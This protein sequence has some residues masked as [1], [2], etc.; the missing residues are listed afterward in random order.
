MSANRFVH[1]RGGPD[2]LDGTAPSVDELVQIVE[3]YVGEAGKVMLDKANHVSNL[4]WIC[5]TLTG[6]AQHPL[7]RVLP[8]D[9]KHIALAQE[10]DERWFEVI[11]QIQMDTI[12]AGVRCQTIDVLTRQQ[13]HYTNVVADGLV[14]LLTQYYRATEES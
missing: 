13:D 1:F 2:A 5:C 4:P 7:R 10:G 8:E 6:K 14:K 11:V 3:D 12:T 9:Q